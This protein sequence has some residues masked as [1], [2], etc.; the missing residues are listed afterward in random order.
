VTDLS[1]IPWSG[2]EAYGK[3]LRIQMGRCP[4]RSIFPEAIKMLEKKQHL[5]GFMTDKIMPLTDALEGYDL[6][7]G[8]KVQKV[9]FEAQK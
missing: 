1:Q 6:F 9:V 3:N 7:N 5:L 4:V 8:M 2:S